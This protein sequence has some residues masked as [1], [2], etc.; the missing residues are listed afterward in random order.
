MIKGTEEWHLVYKCRKYL[1]PQGTI[2]ERCK[3]HLSSWALVP[4]YQLEGQVQC[5]FADQGAHRESLVGVDVEG[6]YQIVG[7]GI[8]GCCTALFVHDCN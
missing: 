7:V 2:S 1:G 8:Y 5:V 4:Q 6:N 3:C